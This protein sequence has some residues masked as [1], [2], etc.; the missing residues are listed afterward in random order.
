MSTIAIFGSRRQQ[1]YIGLIDEF[2]DELRAKGVDIVM[3]GKLYDHLADISPASTRRVLR[4]APGDA[5]EAAVAVS[6]GGDGTFLRTAMWVGEQGIPI[7]GVNTGHLGYLAALPVELLPQL[8]RLI[9]SDAFVVEYRTMISVDSPSLPPSVGRYALNEVCI[10]KE[11]SASMIYASVSLDGEPLADYK[12]D[13]LLVATSTGST[14]YNL[15][16]GGPIVQPTVPVWVI[17]PVAAHSL[18]MRPMVVSSSAHISIVPGGRTAH[19][20]LALDGRSHTVDT[21]TEICLS[22]APFKLAVL[23]LKDHSFAQTLRHKLHWAE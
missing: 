13:G 22:E 16:V 12:A 7:V 17:S 1:P 8:P 20:R 23:Q 15:S 11:E 5:V 19:V 21:G 2:L 6:L 9:A 14:A 18:A 10:A 3:H 4:C